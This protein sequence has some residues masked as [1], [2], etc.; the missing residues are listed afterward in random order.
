LWGPG[1]F[2]G[3]GEALGAVVCIL[4]QM[5]LTQL[6]DAAQHLRLRMGRRRIAGPRAG[7]R[8]V[9]EGTGLFGLLCKFLHSS[10]SC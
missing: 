9:R 5:Q 7:G 3:T 10:S 6:E 2:H 1:G 8:G 4:A